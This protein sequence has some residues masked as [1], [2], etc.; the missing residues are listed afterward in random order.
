M[1]RK[2]HKYGRQRKSEDRTKKAEA[3]D[4]TSASF[5][6][7]TLLSFCAEN[8]VVMLEASVH[9]LLKRLQDLQIV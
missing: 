6:Y 2:K 9:A 4:G 3:P 8:L 1:K 7:F 5:Y